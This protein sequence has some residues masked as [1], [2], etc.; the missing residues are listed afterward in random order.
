MQKF[1][2]NIIVTTAAFL[3]LAAGI[4]SFRIVPY[5]KE[6]VHLLLFDD[7]PAISRVNKFIE[8][9][10]TASSEQL[11]YSSFCMDVQSMILRITDC[12]VVKKGDSA[13]VR[14]NNG[15]LAYS[16]PRI[17]DETL[18]KWANECSNLNQTAKE[19]GIPLLYV[20]APE[21]GENKLFP[22]GTENNIKTNCDRFSSLLQ[23]KGVN[24]LDLREKKKEQNI[25]DEAMFFITDHH[26]KPAYG[27][28]ATNEIGRKLQADYGFNYNDTVAV[29]SNYNVHTYKDWF[30]GSQGKVVGRNF[31]Q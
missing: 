5:F 7:A 8:D 26:W 17:D 29:L 16:E 23:E 20:M 25:S 27:I 6:A 1:N 24:I 30:L 11:N 18:E 3:I 14:L 15:Y 9:I 4:F 19:S 31:N 2:K 21:K 22:A 28:W 10:E 12:R 13:I